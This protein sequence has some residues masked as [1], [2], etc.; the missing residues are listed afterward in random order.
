MAAVLDFI[1]FSPWEERLF[2]IFASIRI[3]VE[4]EP[5]DLLSRLKR[6][7]IR[8]IVHVINIF[9][10]FPVFY[11]SRI[12]PITGF[13]QN[14][15]YIVSLLSSPFMFAAHNEK[16]SELVAMC[17]LSFISIIILL[18]CLRLSSASTSNKKWMSNYIPIRCLR[19]F[20]FIIFECYLLDVFAFCISLFSCAHLKTLR[21]EK[22]LD[23]SSNMFECGEVGHIISCILAGANL[24]FYII[25]TLLV[26]NIHHRAEAI[27]SKVPNARSQSLVEFFFVIFKIFAGAVFVIVHSTESPNA[28]KVA[29]EIAV[30]LFTF[31]MLV[32]QLLKV[33]FK[34][35]FENKMRAV[36]Y[37][38]VLVNCIAAVKR[39]ISMLVNSSK[40]SEGTTV[41]P[42]NNSSFEMNSSIWACLYV[43][44]CIFAWSLACRRL[45]TSHRLFELHVSY[46]F[47]C[48]IDSSW[49]KMLKEAIVD[50][51]VSDGSIHFIAQAI[52]SVSANSYQQEIALK[53]SLRS[54]LDLQTPP[55]STNPNIYLPGSHFRSTPPIAATNSSEHPIGP[56]S[57]HLVEYQLR[58]RYVASVPSIM[59]KGYKKQQDESEFYSEVRSPGTNR[60]EH[61]VSIQP[62][63]EKKDNENID[64]KFNDTIEFL[65]GI[66]EEVR[67]INNAQGK[68]QGFLQNT[69]TSEHFEENAGI[70]N[71]NLESHEKMIDINGERNKNEQAINLTFA[72]ESYFKSPLFHSFCSSMIFFT[73]FEFFVRVAMQEWPNMSPPLQMPVQIILCFIFLSLYSSSS[74]IAAHKS[75]AFASITLGPV[76]RSVFGDAETAFCLISIAAE[77][78][79]RSKIIMMDTRFA[80]FIQKNAV[81]DMRIKEQILQQTSVSKVLQ[82]AIWS[83]IMVSSSMSNGFHRGQHD[84][85][86][87]DA[88]SAL[89]LL[90]IK[91]KHL[92]VAKSIISLMHLLTNDEKNLNKGRLTKNAVLKRAFHIENV[93]RE[94]HRC[95][96][97]Y[98]KLLDKYPANY[99]ARQLY[100]GFK[101]Q[102]HYASSLNNFLKSEIK[103]QIERNERNNDICLDSH[104]SS[105]SSSNEYSDTDSETVVNI[106]PSSTLKPYG[107]KGVK[108]DVESLHISRKMDE[109]ELNDN[110][111]NNKS[112]FSGMHKNAHKDV[113]GGMKAIYQAKVKIIRSI[114]K[115]GILTVILFLLTANFICI[116]FSSQLVLTSD[117]KYYMSYIDATEA[118]YVGFHDACTSVMHMKYL[119]EAVVPFM[120]TP[121]RSAMLTVQETLRTAEWS[122][123]RSD[124]PENICKLVMDQVV[125]DNSASTE[126]ISRVRRCLFAIGDNQ[127]GAIFK[128]W[129]GSG[130]TSKSALPENFFSE[131]L[132]ESGVSVNDWYKSTVFSY[133]RSLPFQAPSIYQSPYDTFDDTEGSTIVAIPLYKFNNETYAVV[134]LEILNDLMNP[135]ATSDSNLQD[136]SVAWEH[137]GAMMAL[138]SR[139]AALLHTMNAVMAVMNVKIDYSSLSAPSNYKSVP[140]SVLN[141]I[142]KRDVTVTTYPRIRNDKILWDAISTSDFDEYSQSKN[143]TFIEL[144]NLWYTSINQILTIGG[145]SVS[146]I[147][148]S[149][150]SAS[151]DF[152]F[153]SDICVNEDVN[154]MLADVAAEFILTEL[155]ENK[156]SKLKIMIVCIC[157]SFI[158]IVLYW[159]F[160]VHFITLKC[161]QPLNSRNISLCARI[162]MEAPGYVRKAII[163]RIRFSRAPGGRRLALL[164]KTKETLNHLTIEED[165]FNN[166]QSSEATDTNVD[167]PL[168]ASSPKYPSRFP[169]STLDILQKR[170]IL[171]SRGKPYTRADI[172]AAAA[173]AASPTVIG[174]QAKYLNVSSSSPSSPLKVLDV[175][176]V[177]HLGH[178]ESLRSNKIGQ[179]TQANSDMKASGFDPLLTPKSFNSKEEKLTRQHSFVSQVDGGVSPSQA[180]SYRRRKKA[181]GRN[182]SSVGYALSEISEPNS[183][184][185]HNSKNYVSLTGTH[186]DKNSKIALIAE[187]KFGKWFE[188]SD[189]TK[190]LSQMKGG[191]HRWKEDDNFYKN[192]PNQKNT[193]LP[194]VDNLTEKLRKR[195]SG[196]ILRKKTLTSRLL[197]SI[198]CISNSNFYKDSSLVAGKGDVKM[199]GCGLPLVLG[200]QPKHGIVPSCIGDPCGPVK[201]L[202]RKDFLSHTEGGFYRST[203]SFIKNSGRIVKIPFLTV[204]ITSL[205]LLITIIVCYFSIYKPLDNFISDVSTVIKLHMHFLS[206]NTIIFQIA[207]T[208]ISAASALPAG[209]ALPES[210]FDQPSTIGVTGILS[211][212]TLITRLETELD[213]MTNTTSDLLQRRDGSVSLAR[214][215]QSRSDLVFEPIDDDLISNAAVV[216]GDLAMD[217]DDFLLFRAVSSPDE[218]EKIRLKKLIGCSPMF[219]DSLNDGLFKAMYSWNTKASEFINKYNI[220]STTVTDTF[221]DFQNPSDLWDLSQDHWSVSNQWSAFRA[222]IARGEVRSVVSK[223]NTIGAIVLSVLGCLLFISCLI[224][225]VFLLPRYGIEQLNLAIQAAKLISSAS[226]NFDKIDR[227]NSSDELKVA[228]LKGKK[229]SNVGN[230]ISLLKAVSTRYFNQASGQWVSKA[231]VDILEFIYEKK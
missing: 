37:G 68:Y 34:D 74:K 28:L 110:S 71:K 57:S 101:Q 45:S 166:I 157:V 87:D 158:S 123:G 116:I 184:Q 48:Q 143:V 205:C 79:A 198:G 14:A 222:S 187:D 128:E 66:N 152:L 17:I 91:S 94:L 207:A 182:L 201:I 76:F 154:N 155:S 153:V 134:A 53:H 46:M 100:T 113:N 20:I 130:F 1:S 209:T 183:L 223:S 164:K 172:Q 35:N 216:C 177:P 137:S 43:F 227:A 131:S 197:K 225:V 168:D 104:G 175:R 120:A 125:T 99:E 142:T 118:L 72:I 224:V 204:L 215:T 26:A 191:K 231:L 62:S 3:N 230:N 82:G 171:G 119:F 180:S 47:D 12:S 108:R 138:R 56:V 41:L 96:K 111:N 50:S 54:T 90:K 133:G 105:E 77:I 15:V 102:F 150:F 24:V 63:I 81:D 136:P 181:L 86:T 55:N 159:I 67:H 58:N 69:N 98:R 199:F 25:F 6:R 18:S 218:N 9:Q 220:G 149:E 208:A 170:K 42:S 190:V 141:Y 59:K 210:A 169:T 8:F 49:V 217:P 127:T 19:L 214:A 203:A 109:E 147:P 185:N 179:A 89:L 161:L 78:S 75:L 114:N 11:A 140:T 2:N 106:R 167:R 22:S 186:I 70:V 107:D 122:F 36:Y 148:N 206:S 196:L 151:A 144:F 97:E 51:L 29:C 73:D 121:Y 176:P 30:L 163:N 188:E 16:Y 189:V 13:N 165:F 139:K 156:D 61:T 221:S 115:V 129:N 7:F 228:T 10:C 33:P 195:Q 112:K 192:Y 103:P 40:I 145:V 31:G 213:L 88:S 21:I 44:I 178:I 5:V 135:S 80:C 85:L 64:S 84:N 211:T 160:C 38:V 65:S 174:R 132:S 146:G 226:I 60:K 39:Y 219:E 229:Q 95:D 200:V 92:S 23:P 117:F 162:L 126:N 193:H 93:I 32:T 52:Q 212:K 173:A 4:E 27:I 202:E 83:G 124:A 194:T